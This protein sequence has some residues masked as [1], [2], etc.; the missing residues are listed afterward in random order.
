LWER[1][2]TISG[3]AKRKAEL[4]QALARP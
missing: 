3:A 4:E 2:L 1:G